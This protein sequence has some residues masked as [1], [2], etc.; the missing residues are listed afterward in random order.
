V[1]VDDGGYGM[2]RHGTDALTANDLPPVDFVGLA[3]SF[4]IDADAVDGLGTDYAKALSAATASGE[5]R[6][7]HVRAQL[8]PPVTTTPFWPLKD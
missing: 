3:R 2:L 6:L 5:P 7:I 8:Q 1:V 4:G